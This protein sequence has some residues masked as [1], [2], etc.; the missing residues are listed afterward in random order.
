MIRATT[1]AI[2]FFFVLGMVPT[3]ALAQQPAP[4]ACA[5]AAA[6]PR[7]VEDPVSQ[8]IASSM[9]QSDPGTVATGT[10]A[11]GRPDP[12][13]A[14][15]PG[16]TRKSPAQAL[17]DVLLADRNGSAPTS[18]SCGGAAAPS[19]PLATPP[20]RGASTAASNLAHLPSKAV[21]ASA[22]SLSAPA[23][24]AP[25]IGSPKQSRPAQ[26]IGV[27]SRISSPAIP[28]AG[29]TQP[30]SP[31][32][33]PSVGGISLPS[34]AAYFLDGDG[35]I[36][37]STSCG[38]PVGT[39][40]G[41]TNPTA[42]V[43]AYCNNTGNE[44]GGIGT[45]IGPVTISGTLETQAFSHGGEIF[46][47]QGAGSAYYVP[48]A[49]NSTYNSFLGA[50]EGDIEAGGPPAFYADG[51]HDF[52]GHPYQRFESGFIGENFGG[53]A[54]AR[55]YFPNLHGV[56]VTS[57]ASGSG[58]KLQF[59]LDVDSAPA[60]SNHPLVT[61]PSVSL[62]AYRAD[63]TALAPLALARNGGAIGNP[64]YMGTLGQV[65]PSGEQASFS[66]TASRAAGDDG[67]TGYFTCDGLAGGRQF[68]AAGATGGV[69]SACPE[70]GSAS[71]DD[72][73]A[74][75]LPSGNVTIAP[76]AGV[77]ANGQAVTV[78]ATG[79]TDDVSVAGLTLL[80]DDVPFPM[81]LS[82][83]TYRATVEGGPGSTNTYLVVATD[84]AGNRAFYPGSGTPVSITSTMP[85]Q[86]GLGNGNFTGSDTTDPSVSGNF[87]YE[88]ADLTVHGKG[89]GDIVLTRSY[90][91]QDTRVGR[92]GL[93]WSSLLDTNY[94]GVDTG[95]AVDYPDGHE[96]VFHDAGGGNWQPNDKFNHDSFSKD[97]SGNVTVV[98][99]DLTRM[100]FNGGGKLQ[101]IGDLS[102]NNTTFS[103]DGGGH[104]VTVTAAGGRS[105]NITYT[106]D[107][108]TSI[109]APEGISLSYTYN[110]DQEPTLYTN[111]RGKTHAYIYDSNKR[112]TQVLSPNGATLV[113]ASY[114]GDGRLNT[115]TVGSAKTTTF[116]YADHADKTG[117]RRLTDALGNITVYDYDKMGRVVKITD[118]LAGT[119]VFTYDDAS[120]LL[121]KVDQGG[122]TTSNT[123][124]ADGDKTVETGPLGLVRSWTYNSLGE[125]TRVVDPDGATTNLAYDGNGNLTSTSNPLG[126]T[127][128]ISYDGSGQPTSITDFGG[129][130]TTQAY[131]SN[132]DVVSVASPLAHTRHYSYDGLGRVTGRT[133][134][135]GAAY[136]YGYDASGNLLSVGGPLSFNESFSYDDNDNLVTELDAA[137]RTTKHV[138]DSS[139]RII[140]T[141]DPVGGVATVAYNAMGLP[142]GTTDTNGR[143]TT[144]DYDA[145]LRKIAVHNSLGGPTSDTTYQYDALNNLTSLKLA[146]G[147]KVTYV[148]DSLSR[149]TQ[150]VANDTGG[151]QTAD[152]NVRR[153]YTYDL[154]NRPL[155]AVDPNGNT[156]TY[157]YDLLGRLLTETDPLGHA[158]TYTYNHAGQV[159]TIADRLGGTA[160]LAYD[161]DGE[162]TTLVDQAGNMSHYGYDAAGRRNSQTDALGVPTSWVFDQLGRMTSQVVNSIAAPADGQTR[163]TTTFS[164][165][166]VG[167]LVSQ[168]DPL[169]AT[170]SYAYDGLN[171]LVSVSA[172]GGATIGYSYDH[173]GNL[174]GVTDPAGAAS[175]FTYDGLNRLLSSKD[176]LGQTTTFSYQATPNPVQKT[177]PR[178]IK[179]LFSYDGLDRLVST[180]ENYSSG[181]P[182][183]ASTNVSTR[184]SYDAVGNIRV[185]TD[186]NGH[187]VSYTY[188]AD[189]RPTQRTDATNAVTTYSYDPLGDVLHVLDTRGNSQ[190]YAYDSLARVVSATDEAGYT[191]HTQYDAAGRPISVTDPNQI[192]TLTVYDALG[193]PSGQVLNY[194]AA[195]PPDSH[196]NVRTSVLYD[197]AGN[198]LAITDGNGNVTRYTYDSRRRPIDRQDALNGV[199]AIQY[200]SRG[201]TT[202]V[203]DPR[204][205]VTSFNYDALNRVTQA[206]DA[207]GIATLYTYDADGNQV[208]TV[209]RNGRTSHRVYD[210]L[211]RGIQEVQNFNGGPSTSD[212]NVTRSVTYDA[213]SN[214]STITDPSGHVTTISRDADN[215]PTRITNAL[216]AVTTLGYDS[217]GNATQVTDPNGHSTSFQYD[218]LNRAV[219]V[220]DALGRVVT[221]S[222][223]WRGDVVGATDPRSA[224]SSATYDPLYRVSSRS[225]ALGGVTSNSYDGGGDLVAQTDQLGNTTHYGYDV[226]GRPI[227]VTNPEGH[228]VAM[229]YDGAGNMTSTTDGNGNT[230]LMTYDLDGRLV[231]HVDPMG[232][233]TR[234]SYDGIGNQVLKVDPLGI[235]TQYNYDG[236]NRL[237]EVIQNY[238][239]G[240]GSGPDLN[241]DTRYA[242]D[243]SGNLLSSTDPRGKVTNFTY[244]AANQRQSETNPLGNTWTYGYDAAGNM[245]SRRTPNEGGGSGDSYSYT[246]D[247]QL[248]KVTYQSGK[249]ISYNYDANNNLTQVAEPL[250]TTSQGFDALNR[251]TS[252]TDALGRSLQYSYDAASRVTGLVYPDSSQVKYTYAGDGQV[253]SVTDPQGKTDTA[254]YDNADNLTRID[255]GNG[256]NAVMSYDLAGRMTS[257]TN[258]D[259][260]GDDFLKYAYAYDAAGN[261]TQTVQTQEHQPLTRNYTY[262][263]LARLTGVNQSDGYQAL[264]TYDASGNR[265]SA[266]YPDAINNS[267]TYSYSYNDA[268]QLTQ[269]NGSKAS[270][271]F[272]YDADGNRTSRSDGKFVQAYTYNEED[273]LASATEFNPG[274]HAQKAETVD[275]DALG[276]SLRRVWWS[277]GSSSNTRTQETTW[278]GMT[279]AADYNLDDG[280]QTIY[281]RGMGDRILRE[282]TSGGSRPGS[283]T[284][285]QDRQNSI[286]G[287]TD[288]SG[289]DLDVQSYDE[290][291]RPQ[292]VKDHQ[293]FLRP[294]PQGNIDSTSPGYQG[295]PYDARTNLNT[296]YARNYDPEVGQWTSQDAARGSLDQPTSQQ[297]Y[298][299]AGDNPLRYTDRFGFSI[300][301]DIGDAV[302]SVANAVVSAVKTVVNAVADAVKGAVDA[303]VGVIKDVIKGIE[304]VV[305]AVLGAIQ[306]IVETV[307]ALVERVANALANIAKQV[308]KAVLS[309]AERIADVVRHAAEAVKAAALAVVR[310]LQAAARVVAQVIDTVLSTLRD[311]AKAVVR[312]TTTVIRAVTQLTRL[313]AGLVI[314]AVESLARLAGQ[315]ING[316][317]RL[318]VLIADHVVRAAER[319]AGILTDIGA[320]IGRVVLAAAG[321]V[322]GAIE[323]VTRVT[324]A[325]VKG[326][327]DVAIQ[328]GLTIVDVARD[329]LRLMTG[330]LGALNDMF[331]SAARHF[332][333]IGEAAARAV[334]NTMVAFAGAAANLA[335]RVDALVR[336]AAA[337]VFQ[338]GFALARGLRGAIA[339]VG[340]VLTG[341][342][343]ILVQGIAGV[344]REILGQLQ[345]VAG[346]VLATKQILDQGLTS[347]RQTAFDLARDLGHDL[348][349]GAIGEG[350][351]L[352]G[353]AQA[354]GAA[355]FTGVRAAASVVNDVARV[356]VALAGVSVALATA[357]VRS[358]IAVNANLVWAARSLGPRLVLAG[359]RG[360]SGAVMIAG[361]LAALT[362]LIGGLSGRLL[363]NDE[364]ARLGL[365][366]VEA[367]EP[368]R[369]RGQLRQAGLALGPLGQ[370]AG[371]PGRF[372]LS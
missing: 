20:S 211:N 118:P 96:A 355:I 33:G 138:Y 313:A 155:T 370:S 57:V 267:N 148:Y 139:D 229:G 198:R 164:Y 209:D 315:V 218:A 305:K 53:G 141:T 269:V 122:N 40:T 184:V 65:F 319:L 44:S 135:D 283:V 88:S 217:A 11:G 181:G 22:R 190:S 43:N 262:D 260:A 74:P 5:S 83:S 303:I 111:G 73:T 113:S 212:Q 274:G 130:V 224:S 291:G 145:L 121:S 105:I 365:S 193:R 357:V 72:A 132:G 359:L 54:S 87:T 361:S 64:H 326:I 273:R 238:H 100:Y 125:I 68:F 16:A 157:T 55:K 248:Q 7:M 142:T 221:T 85:S 143:S 293:G 137:G 178:G 28:V 123:Y 241:V 25:R 126:D 86:F 234:Y 196:T 58:F 364:F 106:G 294:G 230:S 214:I 18:T 75:T 259:S 252:V 311:F 127:S 286:I 8:A 59:D 213:G 337:A 360:L 342:A 17:L 292:P 306:A 23:S 310:V 358:V 228:T 12:Y 354:T 237:G 226:L 285:L 372:L 320:A 146:G 343:H 276:R 173:V 350:R 302:S 208:D 261:T 243:P 51:G 81:A 253:A 76:A 330:D 216:G 158:T 140:Q 186:P 4:S 91:S 163:V 348:V 336:S 27:G 39:G 235:A 169:S 233:S 301:D 187:A 176:A 144:V 170:T 210:G 345:A 114:F 281:V 128:N 19:D 109:S 203:T 312:V 272:L 197:A 295:Q 180:T 66:L 99:R 94:H 77:D 104:P 80:F 48:A 271:T 101:Y 98:T 356:T 69:G 335:R 331:T 133:E 264:Y 9:G 153:T 156:T 371:L 90:N 258:T 199:T 220:S 290:F 52:R 353:L 368:R 166:A 265:V 246:A 297:R 150:Q 251:L 308:I 129:G 192:V 298:N 167:N 168:A 2:S 63:G 288:Q 324:A 300:F 21:G 37:P 175:V 189:N 171:R 347:L 329:S 225:D 13:A 50:P 333:A 134:P 249:V 31:A 161:A 97:G 279:P 172:P 185:V 204:G 36:P 304:T 89:K 103:Y 41:S 344:G 242:F 236:V 322:A 70:P 62:Q 207:L 177:D 363:L 82:G 24:L 321:V 191:T 200:D 115:Q 117:Q 67:F 240:G 195:Q 108:A 339:D 325:L 71:F 34:A 362:A 205:A 47:R 270:L 250:G 112:M 107:R 245:T 328:V 119:Q 268:N 239:S 160:R 78:T 296:F 346:A 341:T 56:T 254:T 188:D 179:T 201:N 95:I 84:G 340:E 255:Y 299:F 275:V 151:A 232:D 42:F 45:P 61:D 183:N 10:A 318:T 280:T 307:V 282:V 367:L 46:Y 136:A 6:D 366:A 26:G 124:D 284:D 14:L 149:M 32:G 35:P 266:A 60:Y 323:L 219:Q 278:N 1:H 165:D 314:G 338:V 120:N 369:L 174:T 215:R 327:V 247:N 147:E 93:G 223:D 287:H 231:K 79:V 256:S 30:G 277:G 263:N 131:D 194:V 352:L 317:A 351:A 349:N 244:G 202:Q 152:R 116:A 289:R 332:K 309:L 227:Q 316:I 38:E 15:H 159:A 92:F 257:V 102:G 182:V 154:L 3:Q 206:T 110:G 162:L 222:Y 29:A 49:F 334:H